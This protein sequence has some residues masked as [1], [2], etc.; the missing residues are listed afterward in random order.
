MSDDFFAEL[1]AEIEK[2]LA[3]SKLKEDAA[4][5][6]KLAFDRTVGKRVREKAMADWQE[7][8]ALLE[9]EQWVPVSVV[10]LFSEQH[11][12]GCNSVH[13][14]FLQYMEMQENVR[15]SLGRR[16][17]RVAHPSHLLPR[18]TMLQPHRTHICAD[19]CDDHDFYLSK[20]TPLTL[21]ASALNISETYLQGDINAP[22]EAN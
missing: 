19:C 4:K 22:P 21:S 5:A 15:K 1:N 9:K 10:A 3:K 11:C 7:M 14:L 18:E 20:A 2:A 13:R 16:W 8:R 17:I 6:K 12:D